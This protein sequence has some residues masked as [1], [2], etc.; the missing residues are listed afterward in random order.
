M[1]P[2]LVFHDMLLTLAVLLLGLVQLA[3]AFAP[4]SMELVRLALH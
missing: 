4:T 2:L 1:R 3:L